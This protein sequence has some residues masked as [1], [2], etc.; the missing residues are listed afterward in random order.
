[1]AETLPTFNRD[2]LDIQVADAALA[3]AIAAALR[4]ADEERWVERLHDRDA[5]LWSSDPAVQA[6]IA[7]RLGWLDS[8]IDFADQA[9]ALE[10]FG[11]AVRDAGFTAVIVAG[12]G[13][14]SLAPDV[15]VD[16]FRDI[17]GWLRVRVLDSTD[18][19]AVAGA[20]DALDPLAT[21]VIVASKSGTTAES[22][23][24]QADAWN[25]T[26]HALRGAG[27]RFESPGS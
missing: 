21:L 22:L 7:N 23:A 26:V 10:A 27:E 12:M 2:V 16:A 4:R 14:S 17:E 18:P 15:L 19:A 13:G 11:E 1:M 8:P 24:F 9:P 5:T 6:K 20:W 25:R 3:D